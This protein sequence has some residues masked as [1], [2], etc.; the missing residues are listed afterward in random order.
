MK[1]ILACL[2]AVALVAATQAGATETL[3]PGDRAAAGGLRGA[4]SGMFGGD[5]ISLAGETGMLVMVLGVVVI[6]G[7]AID[8]NDDGPASP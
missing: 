6:I 7:L 2:T 3:R 5:V 4:Q 8:G 1:R